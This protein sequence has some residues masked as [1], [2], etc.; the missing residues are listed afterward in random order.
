MLTRLRLD[1][2]EDES[3]NLSLADEFDAE[4]EC[5]N[6]I[7]KRSHYISNRYFIVTAYIS[8]I[9]LTI[10][11]YEPD[12]EACLDLLINKKLEIANTEETQDELSKLIKNLAVGEVLGE[13]TITVNL[14]QR[15]AF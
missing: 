6:I 5:Q 10:S 4:E 2:G 14:N 3:W 15:E 7:Y 9:G 1:R 11:A 8:N 13:E 12:K